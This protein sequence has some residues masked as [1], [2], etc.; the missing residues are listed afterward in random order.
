MMRSVRDL[1][2]LRIV[3][4]SGSMVILM[5]EIH[6]IH[7][8]VGLWHF[9][10]RLFPLL[11]EMQSLLRLRIWVS[12]RQKTIT[13]LGLLHFAVLTHAA[14]DGFQVGQFLRREP[15]IQLLHACSLLHHCCLLVALGLD[16]GLWILHH[17]ID[18]LLGAELRILYAY[19]AFELILL[20]DTVWLLCEKTLLVLDLN[21]AHRIAFNSKQS[22]IVIRYDL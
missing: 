14:L 7:W 5:G 16:L 4:L 2:E 19:A 11:R 17:A 13:N 15:S 1:L 22:R 8:L 9:L 6:L 10:S 12:L 18:R 20:N 3:A 21:F